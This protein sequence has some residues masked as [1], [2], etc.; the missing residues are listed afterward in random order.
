MSKTTEDPL[1]PKKLAYCGLSCELD[2]PAFHATQSGDT[3][4]LKS[5]A[6]DWSS[7]DYV[8]DSEDILCDGCSGVSG[9][10]AEICS[11]CKV[12]ECAQSRGLKHCGFCEDFPCQQ[13]K[14]LWQVLKT[15]SAQ[16][17][18]EQDRLKNLGSRFF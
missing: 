17:R 4:L 18:L 2:C 7:P 16:E 3:E 14:L 11:G 5:I 9:R 6:Q 8:L 13:L 15:P 1:E 12:R 10:F